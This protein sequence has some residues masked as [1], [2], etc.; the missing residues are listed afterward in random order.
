MSMNMK[1]HNFGY[2][3][4]AQIPLMQSFINITIN[5]NK[6]GAESTNNMAYITGI[7]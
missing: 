1:R 5:R 7:N 4:Y 3:K 6:S 2:K